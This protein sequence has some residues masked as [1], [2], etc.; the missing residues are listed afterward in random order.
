MVDRTR[1][2]RDGQNFNANPR[3]NARQLYWQ[4]KELDPVFYLPAHTNAYQPG[5]SYYKQHAI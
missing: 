1:E 2:L 3:G 4:R 5:A